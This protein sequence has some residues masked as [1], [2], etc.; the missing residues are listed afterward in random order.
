[1]N[2][3][4]VLEKTRVIEIPVDEYALYLEELQDEDWEHP[5]Y[6]EHAQ[7]EKEI[8]SDKSCKILCKVSIP[9]HV[10]AF[11]IEALKLR[12]ER[13]GLGDMYTTLYYELTEKLNFVRSIIFD[14]LLEEVVRV[15]DRK[16]APKRWHTSYAVGN[17]WK[18]LVFATNDIM[19]KELWRP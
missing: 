4:A 13:D 2:P 10:Q 12:A 6:I 16:T 7:N 18:M 9:F 15:Q 5:L 3:E 8:R 14:W 11:I 17:N 1:M 19:K